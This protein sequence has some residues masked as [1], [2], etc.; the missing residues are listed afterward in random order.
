MSTNSS[1]SSS[2]AERLQVKISRAVL[3]SALQTINTS[4]VVLCVSPAADAPSIS[5]DSC[6]HNCEKRNVA[7]FGGCIRHLCVCVCVGGAKSAID[8]ASISAEQRELQESQMSLWA[9]RRA[10]LNKSQKRC[11]CS[12]Y[13]KKKTRRSNNNRKEKRDSAKVITGDDYREKQRGWSQQICQLTGFFFFSLFLQEK[14]RPP[15]PT[16]S[17]EDVMFIC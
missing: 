3:L 14:P 6:L 8:A 12:V 4:C 1:R 11:Q 16:S 5:V 9:R 2:K 13:D 15:Q 17:S 7:V 10:L